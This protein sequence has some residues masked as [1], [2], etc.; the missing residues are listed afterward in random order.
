[1]VLNNIARRLLRRTSHYALFT[2]VVVY[3]LRAGL[4]LN[5][6]V[7]VPTYNT[8]T[9]QQPRR[10][11]ITLYY[12]YYCYYTLYAVHSM[13]LYALLV[14]TSNAR[15]DVTTLESSSS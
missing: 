14:Y 13:Y 4:L 2:R 11:R 3:I 7:V 6:S 1:M 5:V 15:K 10:G 12:Y 8:T 9:L